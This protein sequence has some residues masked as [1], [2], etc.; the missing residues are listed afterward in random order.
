MVTALWLERQKGA[1]RALA[2]L[3]GHAWLGFARALAAQAQKQAT[4]SRELQGVQ[5]RIW[6]ALFLSKAMFVCCKFSTPDWHLREVLDERFATVSYN[7]PNNI[8]HFAV[9]AAESM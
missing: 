5:C 4:R 2:S 9:D 7:L 3:I 8:H 1:E 6:L